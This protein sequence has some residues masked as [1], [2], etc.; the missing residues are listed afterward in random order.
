MKK[1]Y[2]HDILPKT[3]L[4]NNIK[5]REFNIYIKIKKIKML[6]SGKGKLLMNQIKNALKL[7]L[8]S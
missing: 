3:H 8:K 4:I 5:N 6:F 7:S 1:E 2:F